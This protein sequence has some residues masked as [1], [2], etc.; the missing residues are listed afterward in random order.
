MLRVAEGEDALLGP[1]LLFVA[2]RAPEGGVETVFVER[3]A[4]SD[5]LHHMRVHVRAVVERIDVVADA[6]LVD[7][8]QKIEAEL[9]RH[10]V[11]EFDHL[12]ELPGR[13]DVKKGE[14]R[15]CRIERLH[16]E[17]Q[18]DGRILADRIEHDR[19]GEGRSHFAE[20]VDGLGL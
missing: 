7:V 16:G 18:Q 15:L 12:P 11:A 1:R 14:R 6:V 20:N 8:D 17:M 2:A 10:R 13:I 4:Q 19:L 3:L 9:L 5:R